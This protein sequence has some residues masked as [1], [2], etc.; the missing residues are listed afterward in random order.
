MTAQLA[1]SE[2]AAAKLQEALA[3]AK[4][5]LQVRRADCFAVVLSAWIDAMAQQLMV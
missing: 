4:A 3:V 2:H 5:G 1:A